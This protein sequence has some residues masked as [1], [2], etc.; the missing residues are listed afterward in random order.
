MA[1]FYAKARFFSVA[2]VAATFA[3]SGCF[4]HHQAATTEVLPTPPLK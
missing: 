2:I 1:S 4:H 3:M